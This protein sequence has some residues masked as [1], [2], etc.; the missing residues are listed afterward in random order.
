MNRTKI[1]AISVAAGLFSTLMPARA[2]PALPRDP[3]ITTG[4]LRC[5]VS[6]YI[7]A[8]PTQKGYADIAVIRRGDALDRGPRAMLDSLLNFSAEPP[9]RF[10]ARSGIG[11]TP[12]GYF[13]A[14]GPVTVFHFNDVPTYDMQVADSTLLLAFNLIGES[15]TDQAVIVAGDVDPKDIAGKMDIFS[16]SLL[17]RFYPDTAPRPA[18]EPSASATYLF[19]PAEAA[20]AAVTADYAAAR[21]AP[22]TLNTAQALIMDNFSSELSLIARRRIRAALRDHGIPFGT[23]TYDRVTAATT[24]GP[25]HYRFTVTTDGTHLLPATEALAAALSSIDAGQ[26]APEEF[27]DAMA[28]LTVPMRILEKQTAWPNARY[29]D[30]CAAAFL[31]GTDLA[32]FSARVEYFHRKNVPDST[33]LRLFNSLAA[34]LLDPAASLTLTWRAAPGST[35]D[36]DPPAAFAAAWRTA[37]PAPAPAPA[38]IAAPAA[39]SKLRKTGT[40]PVS[41][42]EVWTFA[43]GLQVVFK[44]LGNDG[45]FHYALFYKGGYAS[46]AD[47]ASGEGGYFSDL[48]GLYR[49]PGQTFIPRVTAS[50]ISLEGAALADGLEATLRSLAAFTADPVCDPAAVDRYIADERI[51]LAAGTDF[52]A[53]LYGIMF[54]RFA[55]SPYKDPARLTPALAARADAFFRERLSGGAILILC[56]DL[57]P[58]TARKTV[59]RY[60]GAF[61]GSWTVPARPSLQYQPR[62]GW[63]TYAVDGE[64][65][66]VR[67]LMSAPLAYTTRSYVAA[68]ITLLAL[69]K[70]LVAALADYGL[71]VEVA[72][73]FLTYP[74]ERLNVTLTCR[75]ASP[76]GLPLSLPDPDVQQAI[77]GVRAGIDLAA[78][79]PVSAADLAGYRAAVTHAIDLGQQDPATLVRTVVTRFSDGKDLVTRH[80]DLAKEVSAEDV[81]A[82]IA[83]LADGPRV[84]YIV[85]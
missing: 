52:D 85:R 1:L 44:R 35:P 5:G 73:D 84:E 18:W 3:A 47:L 46:A 34:A 19:E 83:T 39:K 9:Y 30:K 68:R 4:S 62:S 80:A 15:L 72:G 56:G 2:L 17:P 63:S 61:A 37:A 57:D 23:I 22:G 48:L 31:Y 16:L 43:S 55:Y 33:Q 41:G 27:A 7:V 50:G 14:D 60:A 75:A 82:L 65:P 13:T 54:P 21:P 25:E 81:R 77:S 59:T 32:P 45:T 8:N 29:V 40:E 11:C 51:R 36:A 24:P 70:E 53:T 67:I 28:R 64:E 38:P 20:G 6:Y 42:G 10:L 66:A 78:R 49:T 71:T 69:R 58:E 26:V 79:F 76:A 74:Q 12:S